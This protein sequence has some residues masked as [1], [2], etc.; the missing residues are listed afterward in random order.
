[1]NDQSPDSD[2]SESFLFG[3]HWNILFNTVLVLVYLGLGVMTAWFYV[4]RYEN[5]LM[6][7]K[8]D[9]LSAG[10]ATSTALYPAESERTWY[11][12]YADRLDRLQAKY[13]KW[14][15]IPD[16]QVLPEDFM[17][18]FLDYRSAW[19]DTVMTLKRHEESSG[20]L[21]DLFSGG[22]RKRELEAADKK[23]KESYRRMERIAA[24][25]GIPNMLGLDSIR[26]RK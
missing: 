22:E 21:T 4:H 9:L 6:Q 25:H 11:E 24:K 8:I 16:A 12:S 14:K 13:G 20:I 19:N 10:A 3:D 18:A 26:Q 15:F 5:A 1:M 17:E 2:R 7:V 23:I